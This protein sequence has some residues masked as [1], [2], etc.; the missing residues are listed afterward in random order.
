MNVTR[1]ALILLAISS[2]AQS[3]WGAGKD[4]E[5]FKADSVL[6]TLID[7]AEVAAQEPGVLAEIAVRE[8]QMVT[9]GQLLAQVDDAAAK[10]AER[11]AKTELDIAAKEASN[12]VKVRYAKDT[13]AT[14]KAEFQRATAS[15]EKYRKSV[16]GSEI[17]QLRWRPN[18]LPTRSN[19]PSTTWPW[20]D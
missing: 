13:L 8:G 11:R 6:I 3:S 19:R 2:W 18:K 5:P 17:D 14:A 1:A 12:S 15:I 9:A 10:I 16:T 20:R 4:S 7:Q